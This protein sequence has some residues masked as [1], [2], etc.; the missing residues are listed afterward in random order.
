MSKSTPSFSV[1]LC[2]CPIFAA[3]AMPLESSQRPDTPSVLYDRM[4]RRTRC[5][6]KGVVLPAP[7]GRYCDMQNTSESLAGKKNKS[8]A[9][10]TK[11]WCGE[12]TLALRFSQM[13]QGLGLEILLNLIH[14]DKVARNLYDDDFRLSMKQQISND[15]EEKIIVDHSV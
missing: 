6:R 4:K 3:P 7:C 10:A 1:H 12:G 8:S 13:L 9:R 11:S 14:R 5:K 2:Y 15:F